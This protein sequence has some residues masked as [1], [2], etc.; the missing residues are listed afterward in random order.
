MPNLNDGDPE[1]T[2]ECTVNC[3]NSAE[4]SEK[5]HQDPEHNTHHGITS[6]QKKPGQRGSYV[7]IERSEHMERMKTE[8]L[9]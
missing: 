5:Q 2:K 3:V 1:V 4:R 8:E 9:A 6:W 7:G